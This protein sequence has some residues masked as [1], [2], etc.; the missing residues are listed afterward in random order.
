MRSVVLNDWLSMAPVSIDGA[1]LQRVETE[2]VQLVDITVSSHQFSESLFSPSNLGQ[3]YWFAKFLDDARAQAVGSKLVL[4]AGTDVEI[5]TACSFLAGGYMIILENATVEQITSS[6]QPIAHMFQAFHD[7]LQTMSVGEGLTVQDGW[8]ALHQAKANGWVNFEDEEVDVDSCIDMQ[9]YQHYDNPLNGYLHVI[10]PS[11]LVA[12]STPSN[13]VSMSEASNGQWLDLEGRRFFGPEFY[14]DILGG[15]FGVEVLV[16]CDREE[17]DHGESWLVENGSHDQPYA[18]G[19]LESYD[20]SAFSERGMAV[21]RLAVSRGDGVLPSGVLLRDVDR[22]LTL[23][24]LAPGAIAIHGD[25]GPGLGCGGELLVS[26]LLIKRH[27]FDARSALA[28]TRM[29]HPPAAPR[30][31]AFSLAPATGTPVPISTR[32]S[33]RMARRLSAPAALPCP[34]PP[35]VAPALPDTDS[36]GEAGPACLAAADDGPDWAPADL[37]AA[38]VR[39][40]RRLSL[41]LERHSASAPDVFDRLAL[42]RGPAAELAT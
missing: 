18:L 12:I 16:R 20:D 4:C 8:R 30:S 17:A 2:M 35:A 22:F 41:L 29:A 32:R 21:E 13:L 39:R 10:I 27:G 37:P 25:D 3:L 36:A 33:Y 23:A 24:R 38:P 26:S 1:R 6:F 7:P 40:R 9:E 11:R 28:W 31:L 15:D 34:E 5:V 42:N 19:Q 14:A